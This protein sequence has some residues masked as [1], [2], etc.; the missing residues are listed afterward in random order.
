MLFLRYLG[1]VSVSKVKVSVSKVKGITFFRG[2]FH[3]KREGMLGIKSEGDN[4]L[5]GMVM[6]MVDI[7]TEGDNFF[8]GHAYAQ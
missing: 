4:F 8:K 5:K 2:V 1:F 6:H 7:K 3:I